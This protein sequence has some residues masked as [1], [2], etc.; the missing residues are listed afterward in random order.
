MNYKKCIIIVLGILSILLFCE[1]RNII[2]F[3]GNKY[4]EGYKVSYTETIDS[5]NPMGA[6]ETNYNTDHNI[7]YFIILAIQWGVILISI[8]LLWYSFMLF[9]D[10]W[11]KPKINS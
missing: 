5:T 6:S 9:V 11:H 4:I 7:D 8:G 2:N 10:G 3:Y 1:N